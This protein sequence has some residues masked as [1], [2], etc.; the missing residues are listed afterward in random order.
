MRKV[1]SVS[2]VY[3]EDVETLRFDWG[4]IWML[5]DP[6]TTGSKHTSFGLVEAAGKGHAFH[7][8]ACEE[9]IIYILS[10]EGE[11]HIEGQPPLKLSPGATIFLPAGVMHATSNIG[12]AP[13]RALIAY[14]P[15]GPELDL[16]KMPDCIVETKAK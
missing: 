4:R 3:P 16:Q 9:E 8:H 15:A 11:L 6:R 10:G 14:S 1:G 7:S 13:L 12:K 5:S 2:V